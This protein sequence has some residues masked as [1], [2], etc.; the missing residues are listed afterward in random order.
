MADDTEAIN[1]CANNYLGL[2]GHSELI[3]VARQALLDYGYGMSIVG[4]L[5]AACHH[6]ANGQPDDV[7][8][9]G[10]GHLSST[11]FPNLRHC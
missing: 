10:L 6:R 1:L 11:E 5:P 8:I 2:S 4:M 7:L 9:C 3:E